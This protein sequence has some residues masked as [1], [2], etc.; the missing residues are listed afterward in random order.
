MARASAP[1]EK[2]GL[3][4]AE[5]IARRAAACGRIQKL[6]AEKPMSM[7]EVAAALDLAWGTVYNYMCL[8]EQEGQAVRSG[9]FIKRAELWV[10]GAH[11]V[12]LSKD[13]PEQQGASLNALEHALFVPARGAA[14]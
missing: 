11:A 8:M 4:N 9:R 10:A 12:E 6:L 7:D 1:V 13:T 14:A 5:K 2:R 3:T